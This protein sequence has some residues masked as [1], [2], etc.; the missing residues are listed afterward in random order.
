MSSL[1]CDI[2]KNHLLPKLSNAHITFFDCTDSTNEQAKKLAR[3]GA[4]E[5]SLVI[6]NEQTAG[7]GRMGRSFF[8]PADSGI[9]LSII[10][11][12]SLYIDDTTIITTACSVAVSRAIK[13]VCGINTQIKWVNDILLNGKKVC[14][15]L[16][17]A[18]TTHNALEFIVVGIGIN[19]TN[20]DFPCDIKNK[21]GALFNCAPTVLREELI[22]SIVN[23]FYAIYSA[24]PNTDFMEYY[25]T[26]N[27]SLGKKVKVLCKE[28][29]YDAT[30]IDI[31]NKGELVVETT[32]GIQKIIS[33]GEVE[34]EG[35]Y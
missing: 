10:L 27:A 23:E 7:K 1:N 5:F 34:V 6:A 31:T 3:Q 18:Q 11:R 13:S 30:A 35:L 26:N 28:N 32:D 24:L 33:S 12:P 15:I 16:T 20:A 25:K 21:A 8:S 19:F 29:S 9:Y 14:G 2:I 4:G 22:A 17:Q